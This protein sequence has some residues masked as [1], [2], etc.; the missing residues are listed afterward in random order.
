M[1]CLLLGRGARLEGPAE[2]Q[3][4][5]AQAPLDAHRRT[6][7][8]DVD[9]PFYCFNACRRNGRTGGVNRCKMLLLA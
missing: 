7:S 1:S 4:K 5:A 6:D 9:G 8:H 3:W 2:G